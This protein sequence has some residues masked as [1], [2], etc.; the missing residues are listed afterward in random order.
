MNSRQFLSSE[1]DIEFIYKSIGNEITYLIMASQIETQFRL[2]YFFIVELMVPAK[3]EIHF[4][5][6]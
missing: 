2:L 5:Q 3:P 1:K 4:Y 6:Q